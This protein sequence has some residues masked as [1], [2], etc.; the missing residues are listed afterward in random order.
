MPVSVVSFVKP[1]VRRINY[2][3]LFVGNIKYLPIRVSR[4][5]TEASKFR[6]FLTNVNR[7]KF[8]G[9][10][11]HRKHPEQVKHLP[12]VCDHKNAN[13]YKHSPCSHKDTG[14]VLKST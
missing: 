2:K 1:F 6:T 3:Y 9:A 8:K 14:F 5:V 10:E 11:S 4:K 12:F 7:K 13:L